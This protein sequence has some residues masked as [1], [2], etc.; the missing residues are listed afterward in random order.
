MT[1]TLTP[2][3]LHHDHISIYPFDVTSHFFHGKPWQGDIPHKARER[4]CMG[5]EKWQV[6][7]MNNQ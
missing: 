5:P 1:L 6:S 7:F 2:Q 3:N 4:V